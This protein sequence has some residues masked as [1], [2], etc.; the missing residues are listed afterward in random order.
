MDKQQLWLWRTL[1]DVLRFPL[2]LECLLKEI[3]AMTGRFHTRLLPEGLRA[4][5]YS[6]DGANVLID[7]EIIN[8]EVI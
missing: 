7:T 5:G 4:T 2:Y 3:N 8:A 6:V 1:C